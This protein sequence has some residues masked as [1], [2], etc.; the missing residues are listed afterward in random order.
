MSSYP[1]PAQPQP[2]S[3]GTIIV[4]ILAILAIAGVAVLGCGALAFVFI[5]SS[6]AIPYHDDPPGYAPTPAV[7]VAPLPPASAN[8]SAPTG[9]RTRWVF[10]T[11]PEGVSGE[12][13]KLDD[14]NWEETRDDA[15]NYRFVEVARTP[16]YVELFDESRDLSVQLHADHIRWRRAG[17]NDWIRGQ[18][19]QWTTPAPGE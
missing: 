16:E 12:I 2:G 5:S 4:I 19:G 13:L 10:P 18:T 15:I 8:P 17:Q 14:T 7:A 1:P 3:G 9:D 6:S 11:N